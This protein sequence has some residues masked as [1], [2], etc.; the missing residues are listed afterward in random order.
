MQ[1]KSQIGSRPREL[2]VVIWLQGAFASALVLS[3]L[4]GVVVGAPKA[5]PIHKSVDQQAGILDDLIDW[6]D[7]MLGDPDPQPDPPVNAED[8]W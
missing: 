8:G 7:D 5:D 2:R 3:Q 6:I 1:K 4:A